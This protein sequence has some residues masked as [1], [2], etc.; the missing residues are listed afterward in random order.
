V[1]AV[2]PCC[3]YAGLAYLPEALV[4]DSS[5]A[6][7]MNALEGVS[8]RPV[9]VDGQVHADEYE[10]IWRGLCIG[11]IQKQTDSRHWWWS[12]NVYGEPPVANDRGPA[13]DF[14]DCQLR[15]KLAW[16]RIRPALTDEAIAAATLHACQ[17]QIS[18]GTEGA[19]A[20][21]RAVV[22]ME[23]KRGAARQR[24]LKPGRIAFNGGAID[25]VVR[26]ISD[27]GAAVEVT[28]QLGIPAEFNLVIAGSSRVCQVKWRKENRI[29]V[30]FGQNAQ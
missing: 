8:L 20:P 15:F 22:T 5:K 10:A 18:M 6:L 27:T 2:Q 28:S 16:T 29:G 9:V 4:R 12:C 26:N 11:R 25:C 30:S 1:R 13:I 19:L 17:Q 7:A 3:N 23:S 14:K 24:V 21:E